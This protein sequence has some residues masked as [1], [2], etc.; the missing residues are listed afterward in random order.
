MVQA[1]AVTW[2]PGKYRT[3]TG[4]AAKAVKPGTLAENVMS[5]EFSG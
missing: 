2:I 3:T 1:T 4:F 5:W